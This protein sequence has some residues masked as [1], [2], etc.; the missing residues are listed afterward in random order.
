MEM[1]FDFIVNVVDVEEEIIGE[2]VLWVG[3]WKVFML[4]MCDVGGLFG[5]V[6]N[7]FL[8]GL[9]GCFFY[10]YFFE[11]EIFYI[12]EGMG[13]LRYGD[14]VFLF[15]VGDCIFCLVGM[16][17]VYQIVNMLMD[18]DLIYF[19]IGFYECNEV[20]GYFDSGKVM[21]CLFGVVGFFE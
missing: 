1:F 8:L 20:C 14:C 18:K 13:C 21:V 2:G 15:V 16:K 4:Q 11:D 9:V 7:C 17:V 19:G 12:L 10:W 6:M 5:M 3:F